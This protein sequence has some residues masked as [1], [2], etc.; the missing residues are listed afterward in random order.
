MT[1]DMYTEDTRDTSRE[2]PLEAA[3]RLHDLQNVKDRQDSQSTDW[4]VASLDEDSL[5]FTNYTFD[6][7]LESTEIQLGYAENRK[8]KTFITIC[9]DEVECVKQQYSQFHR[10]YHVYSDI[11]PAFINRNTSDNSTNHISHVF[12]VGVNVANLN[13]H[14]VCYRLSFQ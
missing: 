10:Q 1:L 4:I 11:E 6:T 14:T 5:A 13:E 12:V 8:M 3:L 9:L 2:D 7:S